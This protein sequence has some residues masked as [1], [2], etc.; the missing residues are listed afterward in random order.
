MSDNTISPDQQN[1][2]RN[3]KRKALLA[4]GLVLGIGAAATLAA[5]TDGEFANGTFSTGSFGI[6]GST[7]AD[8]TF[9]EH[10]SSGGAATLSFTTSATNMTPGDTIYAPYFIRTIDGSL[11]GTVANGTATAG[12]TNSALEALLTRDVKFIPVGDTCDAENFAEG[13]TEDED[14][15]A[16]SSDTVQACIE[17]KLSDN[18]GSVQEAGTD[19]ATIVWEWTATSA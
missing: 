7:T 10:A 1:R 9:A 17:V 19:D 12:N 8:G 4:G 13:T 15:G 6:E 11:A 16:D 18:Q 5:F 3:R 2:D 14:L